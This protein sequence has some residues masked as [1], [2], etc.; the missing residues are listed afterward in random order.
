MFFFYELRTK[1]STFI[2]TSTNVEVLK[3]VRFDMHIDRYDPIKG[4]GYVELPKW[5]T[6]I[7]AVINIQNQDNLYFLYAVESAIMNSVEANPAFCMRGITQR[8]RSWFSMMPMRL[9]DINSFEKQFNL[10]NNVYEPLGIDQVKPMSLSSYLGN[11]HIDIMLYKRHY[12]RIISL[13]RLMFKQINTNSRKKFICKR[14]LNY[15]YTELDLNQRVSLCHTHKN[16]VDS[17]PNEG[18]VV[19]LKNHERKPTHPFVL[20]ADFESVIKPI[21]GCKPNTYKSYTTQR[22]IYS[23]LV[24]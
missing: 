4:R 5:I 6:R 13:S 20:Y 15:L 16:T 8:C 10:S 19:K 23:V 12:S 1:F 2:S 14:C 11:N 17:M 7:K 21:H 9:S 18:G 24:L 3:I 22:Q